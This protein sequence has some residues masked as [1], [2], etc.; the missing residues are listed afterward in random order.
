M[1]NRRLIKFYKGIVLVKIH[2]H[3]NDKD[4]SLEDLDTYLKY[5][6]GIDK[7]TCDMTDK[8]LKDL[9]EHSKQFA[10]SIGLSID[11]YEE[12]NFKRTEQ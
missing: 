7:S 10:E 12:L 3:I 9:I 6:A 2:E 4:I 5:R 1:A 11:K 8:E